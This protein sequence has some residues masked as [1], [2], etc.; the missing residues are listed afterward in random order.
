MP[1]GR[2]KEALHRSVTAIITDLFGTRILA[3]DEKAALSLSEIKSV[4]RAEGFQIGMADGQIAAIARA[5]EMIVAT[6]D[7]GPF[8][9]AGLTV[10][11]PWIQ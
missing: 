5:N 6:R 3:F 1:H 4:S 9:T 11:N 8:K 10:V 2:W 7:T